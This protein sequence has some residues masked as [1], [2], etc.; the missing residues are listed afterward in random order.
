MLSV[1]EVFELPCD[2]LPRM[3]YGALTTGSCLYIKPQMFVEF[4]V[5]D[6]AYVTLRG[7]LNEFAI[8]GAICR[9]YGVG[10]ANRAL[11]LDL[12]AGW[13]GRSIFKANLEQDSER[14]FSTLG[15]FSA[16]HSTA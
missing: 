2:L 16:C 4:G 5:L 13:S 10:V 15:P 6:P 8:R 11:L 14:L 1:A 3:S 12:Q 7:S 9:G